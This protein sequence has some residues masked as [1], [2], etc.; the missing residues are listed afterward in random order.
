MSGFVFLYLWAG[1]W[2]IRW[3]ERC[4][5]QAAYSE[6][7]MTGRK[8]IVAVAMWGWVRAEPMAHLTALFIWWW[9]GSGL[10]R[11]TPVHGHE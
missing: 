9:S 6:F 4:A 1:T 8:K 3:T 7:F 2:A 5:R 11:E 10:A